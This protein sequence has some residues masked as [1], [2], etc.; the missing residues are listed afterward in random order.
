M[1]IFF[2]CVMVG[3]SILTLFLF[4]P[5]RRVEGSQKCEKDIVITIER[6][7][8]FGDCPVYSAQ[9]HADGEVVYVGKRLVKEIGE[10][11]FKISQENLR[12]II[13]EFERIDYFS[14]K[15]RYETDENG[16]SVTDLPTT[17]T[18][19]C[20]DGKKKTVVN[21]YNAP[22]KLFELEDKIDSL[23]GLYKYLGPL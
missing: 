20:L 15:D 1:K 12:R 19:I 21:Y 22:K 9:I 3:I 13:K 11:R 5:P 6:T 10:R 23:A 17:T 14:L 7:S 4:M 2:K 8:C 16:M 18:S